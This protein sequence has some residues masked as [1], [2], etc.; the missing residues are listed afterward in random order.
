MPLYFHWWSRSTRL[1]ELWELNEIIYI[2]VNPVMLVPVTAW[3]LS[4]SIDVLA[5]G[6]PQPEEGGLLEQMEPRRRAIALV[7]PFLPGTEQNGGGE[8]RHR[9]LP[10]LLVPVRMGKYAQRPPGRKE[11]INLW[12]L[13]KPLNKSR[14]RDARCQL[15]PCPVFFLTKVVKSLVTE[16]LP[17]G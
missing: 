5:A 17:P 12:L 6:S 16:Q 13:R 4:F 10:L 8:G 3:K 7:V 14:G 2:N 1:M 11:Q 9:D 15:L